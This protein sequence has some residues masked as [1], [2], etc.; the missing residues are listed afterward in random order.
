MTALDLYQQLCNMARSS[1]AHLDTPNMDHLW[2]IAVRVNNTG[3]IEHTEHTVYLRIFNK[4][5]KSNFEMFFWDV[6][7]NLVN[8]SLVF[9]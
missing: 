4:P 1:S 2:K 9:R 5:Y 7:F 8:L 3:E 6:S